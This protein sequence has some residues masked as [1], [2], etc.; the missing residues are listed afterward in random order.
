[1]GRRTESISCIGGARLRGDV[2]G[3]G[4][5]STGLAAEAVEG[6]AID[7][8]RL[9]GMAAEEGEGCDGNGVRVDLPPRKSKEW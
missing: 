5:G 1:M 9:S 2:E 4:T 6:T 3:E 7:G 8:D